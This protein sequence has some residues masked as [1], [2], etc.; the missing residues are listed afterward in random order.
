M[1]QSGLPAV[2]LLGTSR[3]LQALQAITSATW[4][5]ADLD[6]DA[7]RINFFVESSELGPS[8]RKR[9]GFWCHSGFNAGL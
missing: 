3:R 1:A 9:G 7:V 8:I 4:L 6:L 5:L 2:K